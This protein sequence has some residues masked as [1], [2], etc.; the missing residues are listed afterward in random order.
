[1]TEYGIWINYD[2]T[3]IKSF[4]YEFDFR[5]AT[6]GNCILVNMEQTKNIEVA[7]SSI[8][9]GMGRSKIL[10]FL[11]LSNPLSICILKLIP[12]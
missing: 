3:E 1:M 8:P 9:M 4:V 2:V 11:V 5:F 12:V 10:N 7:R 6:S